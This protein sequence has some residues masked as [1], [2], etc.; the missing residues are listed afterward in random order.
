MK[1]KLPSTNTITWRT[2][3]GN[4]KKIIKKK[5]ERNQEKDI[6]TPRKTHEQPRKHKSV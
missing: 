5:N 6:D 3:P 1:Y 2:G 4:G